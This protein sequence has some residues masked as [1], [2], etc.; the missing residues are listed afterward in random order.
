MHLQTFFDGP[1]QL[2]FG[3]DLERDQRVETARVRH[4]GGIYR[5]APVLFGEEEAA[6][7]FRRIATSENRN[8]RRFR[9]LAGGPFRA[10]RRENAD[11]SVQ[12]P[13]IAAERARKSTAMNSRPADI[14]LLYFMENY[15]YQNISL[16][17]KG[18]RGRDKTAERQQAAAALPSRGRVVV[19]CG[20][21]AS[22][23]RRREATECRV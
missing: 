10:A 6:A 22:V 8:S 14:R 13:T 17:P 1:P 21:L 15:R 16:F 5:C 18:I 4:W 20:Q 23:A 19:S 12:P 2:V 7:V 3:R 11:C 9:V